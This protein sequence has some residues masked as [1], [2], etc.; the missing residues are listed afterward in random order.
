MAKLPK[1][2]PLK[3]ITKV[4]GLPEPPDL[5]EVSD[6]VENVKDVT[7]TLREAK[8]APKEITDTFVEANNEFREADREFRKSGLGGKPMVKFTDLK[9]KKPS[10]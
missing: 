10:K 7:S 2:N 9:R 3:A 4:L 6:L 5:P 8:A 1:N